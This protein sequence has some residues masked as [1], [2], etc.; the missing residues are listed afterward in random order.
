MAQAQN[1][2][3]RSATVTRLLNS[4]FDYCAK[5]EIKFSDKNT[6]LNSVKNYVEQITGKSWD[7]WPASSS[8]PVLGHGQSNLICYGV[9][10]GIRRLALDLMLAEWEHNRFYCYQYCRKREVL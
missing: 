6:I 5:I 9:N 3:E 1:S 4:L 7:W 8:V 10:Y 2:Q